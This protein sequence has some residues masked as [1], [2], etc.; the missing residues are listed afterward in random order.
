[1]IFKDRTQAG[2]ELAEKLER[3]IH[4]PAVILAIPRGGVPIGCRIAMETGLPMQILFVKKI[5]HPQNRE[6]AIGAVGLEDSYL[7]PSSG[8]HDCYISLE[9][10]QIRK[11]LKSMAEKFRTGDEDISLHNKTL[12]IVNDGIATD[13][14][15]GCAIRMLRKSRP[16]AIVVATP[17]ASQQAAIT[18]AR[19]ADEFI[20]LY[21]PEDFLS[22][23]AYYE[24]FHPLGDEETLSC[25]HL[26]R[27]GLSSVAG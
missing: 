25:L 21:T 12:I 2:I 23:G 11:R 18:L 10:A 16:A 19:I 22:V 1:M 8:V 7:L 26:L 9:T 13:S 4:T 6:N 27:S 20:G 24:D 5:G 14:M 15:I 3:Y 17:V